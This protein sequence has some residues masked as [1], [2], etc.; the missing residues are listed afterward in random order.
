MSMLTALKESLPIYVKLSTSCRIWSFLFWSLRM[1]LPRVGLEHDIGLSSADVEVLIVARLN[2]PLHADLYDI[3]DVREKAVASDEDVLDDC[4]LRLHVCLQ[5]SWFYNI[6]SVPYLKWIPWSVF[7]KASVGTAMNNMWR[8][9]TPKR[10]LV[11]QYLWF[12]FVHYMAHH[13]D[14]DIKIQLTGGSFLCQCHSTVCRRHTCRGD[15]CKR[16]LSPVR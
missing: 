10:T 11:S 9:W 12:A 16:F 4:L 7:W 5:S 8:M 1:Y 15:L 6:L 13:A 2:K 14:L 3:L